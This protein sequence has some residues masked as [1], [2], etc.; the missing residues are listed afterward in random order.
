MRKL[1]R[2]SIW[3]R[4]GRQRLSMA[5]TCALGVCGLALAPASAQ[6][7]T[8]GF[9]P[10]GESEDL[11]V[12]SLS[13]VETVQ[14]LVDL[15]Q[16]TADIVSGLAGRRSALILGTLP[17]SGDRSNRLRGVIDIAKSPK[18]LFDA[19]PDFAE[20]KS[21]PFGASTRAYDKMVGNQQSSQFDAW[22]KGTFALLS[23][24]STAGQFGAVAVGVDQ[25]VTNDLLIGTFAQGDG[26]LR[27]ENARSPLARGG[28]TLGGYGTWRITDNFYLDTLAGHGSSFGAANPGGLGTGEFKTD[29]W[30]MTTAIAGD[31]EL[32]N[33][34]FS[35]KARLRY[36][37]EASTSYA[38][39]DG[40]TAA[41]SRGS[42]GEF[43]LSPA[44]SHLLTTD[45]NLTIETGLKFETAT[46]LSSSKD[47]WTTLSDFNGRLEGTLLLKLPAGAR[48]K[49]TIGYGGIGTINTNVSLKTVL[50]APIP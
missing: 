44:V 7:L 22:I 43:A 41:S 28:W 32:N 21:V 23:A 11:T 20:G 38:A 19:L 42:I 16:Q 48:I 6:S 10:L 45:E 24:S 2:I 26:L 1:E 14:T 15:S 3:H 47:L 36:F 46:G 50:N 4:H 40:A 49:S 31:W 39:Q 5:L 13:P 8:I 17:T 30:I 9:D 18:P 12:A 33:W 34:S 35:P 27:G 29:G 37:E 25:L